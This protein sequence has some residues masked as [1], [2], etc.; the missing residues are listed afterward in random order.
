MQF[1]QEL[2]KSQTRM[3]V[4]VRLKANKYYQGLLCSLSFYINLLNLL[5]LQGFRHRLLARG[6]FQTSSP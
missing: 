5:N 6:R 4:V 2:F 3:S 1:E